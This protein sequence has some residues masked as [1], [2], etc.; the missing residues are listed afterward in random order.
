VDENDLARLLD[1]L[2]VRGDVQDRTVQKKYGRAVA[3]D[4]LFESLVAFERR[5]HRTVLKS[6]QKPLSLV[7]HSCI[8]H[9]RGCRRTSFVS[10]RYPHYSISRGKTA[11]APVMLHRRRSVRQAQLSKSA[12]I[13]S[14]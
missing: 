4:S 2:D 11:T 5:D 7:F 1:P 12:Q 10:N 6:V 3:R 8:L 9:R 14:R 13:S